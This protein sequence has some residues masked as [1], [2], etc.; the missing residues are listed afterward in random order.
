VDRYRRFPEAVEIARRRGLPVAYVAS[1]R[2]LQRDL[3]TDSFP[4]YR[5]GELYLRLDDPDT[6]LLLVMGFNLLAPP[7]EER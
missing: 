3:P 5:V 4:G 6:S 2:Q 1:V 7:P